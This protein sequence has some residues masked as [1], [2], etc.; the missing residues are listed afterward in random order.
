MSSQ[1]VIGLALRCYPSWWR[2][3]YA[4]EVRVVSNDLTA[5]GRSSAMVT[6]NLLGGALRSWSGAR[7]MP[8]TYGLWSART[9]ASIATATL[10]WLLVIPLVLLTV[11]NESLHSSAGPVTW[12]GPSSIPTHLLIAGSR[13]LPAPAPPLTPV[14]RL[15]LLA[16]LAI[17][18]LSLVTFVVLISGWSGLTGAIRRSASPHRRRLLALAWVPLISMVADVAL[19]IAQNAVR[20]P[21]HRIVGGD[22]TQRH[23]VAPHPVAYDPHPALLHLLNIVLPTVVDVGWLLSIA[24]VALA[25]RRAEVAPSDLQF[26]KSVAVVVASLFALLGVAYATWGVGLA[27]QARQVGNGNYTTVVFPLVAFWPPVVI[28]L[29]IGVV[30]SGLGARSARQSWRVISSALAS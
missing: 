28:V 20:Y 26:G 3:R 21:T 1:S 12:S 9:K 6:L 5:E 16:G 2:E 13:G 15:V 23:F 14:G 25:A 22:V 4:D 19:A 7:G 27:V 30:L 11:G 8:K 24:C 29:L 17:V 18:L 10:S